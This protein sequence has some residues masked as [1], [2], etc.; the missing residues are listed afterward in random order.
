MYNTN[1][2]REGCS[3][4]RQDSLQAV[5]E[6]FGPAALS[7]DVHT[8][9][10]ATDCTYCCLEVYF[11]YQMLNSPLR[12][13]S[14]EDADLVYVPLYAVAAAYLKTEEIDTL[15]KSFWQDITQFLP[16]LD[17]KLH[18]VFVPGVEHEV[19]GQQGGGWGHGNMYHPVANKLFWMVQE[20]V[21]DRSNAVHIP[22]ASHH[23]LLGFDSQTTWN[24]SNKTLA[25][26][27]V[28][29]R[30]KGIREALSQ[31]CE[32]R[33]QHCKMMMLNGLQAR[34][35]LTWVKP[36]M[37]TLKQSWYCWSPPGD[38]RTRQ[39]LYD[40]I[41][42]PSIPVL[43]DTLLLK[44]LPFADVINY[45]EIVH[46]FDQEEVNTENVVD[47]LANVSLEEKA[48]KTNSLWNLSRVFQY[49]LTP[50]HSLISYDSRFTRD[51][52]DDAFTF[53][54][55]ALLRKLCDSQY[56]TVRC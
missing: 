7:S 14:V 25:A 34:E 40:C 50:K 53:S 23:H 17:S 16:M 8:P 2:F 41:A 39:G 26:S 43:F 30:L 10:W 38:T 32:A 51:D 37:E 47:L 55:K 36:M 56:K 48:M 27:M 33:P 5:L 44:Q 22:Y 35:S 12:T 54:M 9:I 13:L 3:S 11:H 4:H 24:P 52:M 18:F 21:G 49:A 19:I 45:T 1:L 46:V 15:F 28:V 29:G 20:T 31:Q 6:P 42:A